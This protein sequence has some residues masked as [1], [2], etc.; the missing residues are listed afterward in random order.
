MTRTDWTQVDDDDLLARLGAALAPDETTA[1]AA[2]DGAV[3]PLGRGIGGVRPPLWRRPLAWAAAVLLLAGI[4]AGLA[5]AG[6]GTQRVGTVDPATPSSQTPDADVIAV[7]VL[8]DALA[9]KLATGDPT[10]ISVAADALR[11]SLDLLDADQRALVGDRPATLLGE[12][13]S[14]LATTTTTSTP[15]GPDPGATTPSVPTSV[16]DDGDDDGGDDGGDTGTDDSGS[17]NSGP[18]SESSGSD[19]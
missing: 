18:G 6:D 9:L 17:D 1:R 14:L 12:A 19:D 2:I 7:R 15:T 16:D 8:A 13:A 10:E 5:A 11:R 3:V 4:A